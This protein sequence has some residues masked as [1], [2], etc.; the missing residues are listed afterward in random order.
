MQFYHDF[1]VGRVLQLGPYRVTAE[2]I[3]EFAAEFDPQPFHLDGNSKQAELT[4]GLIASGWHTSAIL[5][6]MMCDAY[7]LDTASQGSG[8]L[9][10]VRWLK[11]VRPGDTLSGTATVT[12]CRISKSRPELGLVDFEYDLRNQNDETVMRVT[13]MGMINVSPEQVK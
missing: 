2:E 11:P 10:Q 8:G 12:G 9:D 5:M 13:G 1:P 3:V 4:G 6:R 7:L